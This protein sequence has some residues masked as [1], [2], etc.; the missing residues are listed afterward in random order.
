MH[1][2]EVECILLIKVCILLNKMQ[3]LDESGRFVETVWGVWNSS[4]DSPDPPDPGAQ[5]HEALFG[6]S[7][8]HA[9][10]VRMT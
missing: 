7:I 8:P 6:T 5:G 3:T 9:P 2:V 1:S 4:P 10:G